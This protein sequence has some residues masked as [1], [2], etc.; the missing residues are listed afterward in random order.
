MDNDRLNKTFVDTQ[1]TMLQIEEY[2]LESINAPVTALPCQVVEAV[3]AREEHEETWK[4]D[5]YEMVW[6]IQYEP[7]ITWE[8]QQGG[9]V[10][11]ST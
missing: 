2:W 1:K 5:K 10:K 11:V 7:V 9:L 3:A 4:E 8:R 6:R